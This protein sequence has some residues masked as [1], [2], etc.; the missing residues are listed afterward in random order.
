MN[1]RGQLDADGVLAL[2]QELSDRLAAAGVSAQLFVVGGAAMALAYDRGRLTRD[3]DALFVPA[4]E[5][6]RIAE[7]MSGPHGLEPDWLND[8]AK[9]FLPGADDHPRTVF[10]SESLLVQVPSPSYLL[11]MKLHASRDERDLNDAAILFNRLGYTSAQ[12]CIDLLTAT[13][14]TSQLLPRHRYI[15]EDIAARV[16]ARKD[17]PRRQSVK[18]SSEPVK[19]TSVSGI[20][21]GLDPFHDPWQHR[22][23]SGTQ[24]PGRSL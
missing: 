15:A 7:E 24:G 17:T 23:G 3:V 20:D 6:R 8:A 14:P 19:R 10:E 4:P 13:Y 18:R 9:G 2:F 16:H 11:A 21:D 22:P 5:V 1:D 12:D